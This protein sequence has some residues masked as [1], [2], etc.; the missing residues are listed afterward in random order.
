ML[1]LLADSATTVGQRYTNSFFTSLFCL[2][3]RLQYHWRQGRPS[4]K[5]HEL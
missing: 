3:T 4:W 5:C 2:W 1:M